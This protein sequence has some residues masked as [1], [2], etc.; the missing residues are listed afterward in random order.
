MIRE[1]I[2]NE[3]LQHDYSS[4][5]HFDGK[6]YVNPSTAT[7][8]TL[9]AVAPNE[10]SSASAIQVDFD[11]V[12]EGLRRINYT[13]VPV[14]SNSSSQ[15][16][17]GQQD[18]LPY[19]APND[20]RIQIKPDDVRI[21]MEGEVRGPGYV[22]SGHSPSVEGPRP[23]TMPPH[24]GPGHES[25]MIGPASEEENQYHED[26][27][28]PADNQHPQLPAPDQRQPDSAEPEIV[29]PSSSETAPVVVVPHADERKPA[30]ETVIDSRPHSPHHDDSGDVVVGSPRKNA[31]DNAVPSILEGI[32]K[33][34]NATG[35]TQSADGSESDSSSASRV[36]HNSVYIGLAV[37]AYLLL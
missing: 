17:P 11:D 14:S 4:G 12:V 29:A 13:V 6:Q 9:P 37:S 31:H 33:F 30:P 28:H 21:P 3:T 19:V 10:L 25:V 1:M 32:G 18:S 27:D 34:F 2:A 26:A 24:E 22:R 35:S 36:S 20:G 15:H 23:E 16:A 7:S 5:N 8:T